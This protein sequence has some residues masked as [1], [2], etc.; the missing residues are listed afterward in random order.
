[1]VVVVCVCVCVY[2][3]IWEVFDNRLSDQNQIG[4]KVLWLNAY[5]NQ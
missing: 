4:Q 1:M 2:A 5:L 3:N